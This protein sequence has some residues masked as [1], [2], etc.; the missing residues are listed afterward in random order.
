MAG[1]SS[2]RVVNVQGFATSFPVDPKNSVTLGIGRADKRD[3]VVVKV[4]TEAG[5]VGG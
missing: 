3:A 4:T 2:L 5:I 1:V